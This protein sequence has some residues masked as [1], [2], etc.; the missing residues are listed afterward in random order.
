MDW[1]RIT[2]EYLGRLVNFWLKDDDW[3][4]ASSAKDN[5]MPNKQVEGAAHAFNLISEH[6]VV[7]IA[8]EV[9]MGKT[10]QSLAVCAAL[11]QQK[12][13]ARI[14]VLTPREVVA[15]NWLSEYT[16]FIQR[17]LRSDD[18][19]LRWHGEAVKP[20][21][22]VGNLFELVEQVEAQWP[23][24]LVG[25][26]TSFSGLI[27][28]ERWKER[29]KDWGRED[30]VAE[31]SGDKDRLNGRM[32]SLIRERLMAQGQPPFDL[33]IIDEAHYLRH[34]D[35]DSYRAGAAR[36][37]FGEGVAPPIA[38]GVL[39]LT[40]TP[41]HSSNEDVRNVLRYFQP[42]PGSSK[43]VL[44]RLCIR[45][46]RRLGE[47]GA[48]KYEYRHEVADASNF[49][50]DPLAESFFGAYQAL[51]AQNVAIE[52]ER[53]GHHSGV[54]GMI[55]YLEGVEFLPKPGEQ[56][57]DEDDDKENRGFDFYK[58]FD[59]SLLQDLSQKFQDIFNESPRH[60]KYEA[61]LNQLHGLDERD[62]KALVFVRRI[63]SVYEITRRLMEQV[64]RSLLDELGLKGNVRDWSRERFV[65]GSGREL[66]EE[67]DDTSDDEDD[68]IPDSEVLAWFKIKK[69][70]PYSTTPASN[71]R[72]LF[73]NSKPG[74]FAMFFSPA[75]D[76]MAAQYD[77]LAIYHAVSSGKRTK[78][79]FQS[80]AFHR[81]GEG[82]E[83]LAE[84]QSELEKLERSELRES[85]LP[86][87]WTM[88]IRVLQEEDPQG[89][90][91]RRYEK[92]DQEVKESLARFVEKAVLLA[93]A[94]V[95]W[96]FH[97][98]RSLQEREG[99]RGY[100]EFCKL[101]EE[102]FRKRRIWGQ[103]IE[104]ILYFET[105]ARKVFEL[106]S[107]ASI[108]RHN[109]EEFRHARPCYPFSGGVGSKHA[110][111]CF[112]TPFYPDVLVATSVLQEGVNLQ[113]FCRRVIHYGAAWTAGDNEQRIGRIDRMFSRVERDLDA[114]GGELDVRYPVLLGTVDEEHL[115]RFVKRK[116][117]AERLIDRGA[118]VASD[119]DSFA[120][121]SGWENWR[122]YLNQ[123]TADRHAF[124]DPYPVHAAA[125]IGI[126]PP[127]LL[128][129][130]KPFAQRMDVLWNTLS[131]HPWVQRVLASP[132]QT[133]PAFLLDCHLPNGR[134][135]AVQIQFLLDPRATAFDR[136]ERS[137]IRLTS[138]LGKRHEFK[139]FVNA[140]AFSTIGVRLGYDPR[141]EQS[142]AWGLQAISELP[143]VDSDLVRVAQ[144]ELF[145]CLE[146][147]VKTADEW[148][149]RVHQGT[150]DLP[151]SEVT[152]GTNAHYPIAYSKLHLGSHHSLPHNWFTTDK[153]IWKSIL[154]EAPNDL[155]KQAIDHLNRNF[156]QLLNMNGV[157]RLIVSHPIDDA[158]PAEL[159]VLERHLISMVPA[160]S[161]SNN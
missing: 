160:S 47:R 102:G 154:S 107:N 103:I 120:H 52:L 72:Q 86:T 157:W 55:R 68:H 2:P 98:Y 151:F 132:G 12:P 126:T 26:I 65:Q 100:V 79:Y 148:E 131:G 40:A 38:D 133:S 80:A 124:A 147:L 3:Q 63:A 24:F 104:S 67:E 15:E 35:G 18:G 20:A 159:N 105:L 144:S 136:E 29:L 14:L 112:N 92:M 99:V 82:S 152:E 58:G 161:R 127:A 118:V 32:A 93:S 66:P 111:K 153:F 42:D 141:R 73:A 110:L 39:L 4:Y 75:A 76:F 45:R 11:W 49:Q 129:T 30:L 149:L 97:L 19:V 13:H 114:G 70:D 62:P 96:M 34:F 119:S 108:F 22:K 116:R 25:K 10:I 59:S 135:Q 50:D 83:W 44:D 89:E 91:L 90:A 128:P 74:V 122:D 56:P 142:S 31:W 106:S 9:G 117:A 140:G 115:G 28:G 5:R 85:G 121:D 146:H 37:F 48:N 1:N 17:H 71:F 94:D 21:V 78:R 61:L 95:V 33:I 6:R 64:D 158:D 125:F 130:Q 150:R 139:H 156:V 7:L 54:S 43:E 23:R 84:Y 134:Q 8:D 16:A 138:P 143:V 46:L 69:G 27:Q 155:K 60:P 41:N 145:A 101:F 51:L 88:L 109:W 57:S 137:L 87:L 123:P 36:C 53:K 77:D 113:Y 81:L